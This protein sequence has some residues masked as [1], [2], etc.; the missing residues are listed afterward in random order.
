MP[1]PTSAD[2]EPRSMGSPATVRAGMEQALHPKP[3]W[4]SG[5]WGQWGDESCTLEFNV[6]DED[7][8]LGVSVL[9]RGDP[10]S[11]LL[12]VARQNGWCLFDDGMCEIT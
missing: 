1:S 12:C 8:V 10:T 5:N 7:P 6:G 4:Y 9:V 2:W 11:A 3:A